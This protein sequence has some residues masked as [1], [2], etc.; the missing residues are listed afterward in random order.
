MTIRSDR[1]METGLQ[2]FGEVSATISHEMKNVLAIISEN[3][4]L[5]EDLAEIAGNNRQI[6]PERLKRTC[7]NMAKQIR[8]GDGIM[9]NLNT[10]GHSVDQPVATVDLHQVAALVGS[11]AERQATLRKV[12]I[13]VNAPTDPIVLQTRPFLLENLIWLC[14]KAAVASARP[15]D[16]LRLLP[17]KSE[18]GDLLRIQG[19][20]NPDRVHG[21]EETTIPAEMLA[22]LGAKIHIHLD[23]QELILVLDKS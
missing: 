20:N 13:T 9:K 18:A 12:S 4:G 21:L 22:E 1:S 16:C 3:V 8:R 2:F 7:G 10:F 5:L 11:L 19:V 17:E 23:R 15:G 14:L 6:D